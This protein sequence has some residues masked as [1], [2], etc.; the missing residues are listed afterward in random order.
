MKHN[1]E[2]LMRMS[3]FVIISEFDNYIVLLWS[4]MMFRNMYRN[5][6]I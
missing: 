4:L 2:G 5:L 6:Y 3:G 1:Y